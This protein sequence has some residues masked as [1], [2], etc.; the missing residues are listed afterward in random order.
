MLD[1]IIL[2]ILKKKNG[3]IVVL[4][5]DV[6]INVV[7]LVSHEQS[8]THNNNRCVISTNKFIISA[9]SGIHILLARN[10]LDGAVYKSHNYSSL[11]LKIRVNNKVF[12]H[13]PLNNIYIV[14]L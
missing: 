5:E 8:R 14:Q 7:S 10:I 12:F 9:Y 11:S 4:V 13:M 3:G 1:S 2:T 6:P